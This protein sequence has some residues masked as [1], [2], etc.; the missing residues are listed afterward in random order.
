MKKI[1]EFPEITEGMKS[2]YNYWA[3]DPSGDFW[4][5]RST[6]EI[7]S[8]QWII[9]P[10]LEDGDR[11]KGVTKLGGELRDWTKAIGYLSRGKPDNWDSLWVVEEPK[12]TTLTN[13]EVLTAL[14]EGKEIQRTRIKEGENS[15]K[16]SKV[17]YLPFF[18]FDDLDERYQRTS[19]VKDHWTYRIKPET[20]T[21]RVFNGVELPD[22]ITEPLQHGE[23]YYV[24][25]VSAVGGV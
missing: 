6:P 24:A 3:V 20:K 21:V 17:L 25:G 16:W 4:V 10:I 7:G 14:L 8:A 19:L 1:P 2:K 5:F 22:C 9:N 12:H 18:A 13:R 23:T 15:P 11:A